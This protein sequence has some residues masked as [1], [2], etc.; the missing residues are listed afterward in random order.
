M[1]PP[2]IMLPMPADE[3]DEL[4]CKRKPRFQRKQKGARDGA[5]TEEPVRFSIS[6]NVELIASISTVPPSKVDELR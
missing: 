6:E 4:I 1:L 5:E 2:P 3:I